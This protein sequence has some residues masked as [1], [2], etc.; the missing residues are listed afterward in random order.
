M[1]A[2]WLHGYSDESVVVSGADSDTTI[3]TYCTVSSERLTTID[4]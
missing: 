1:D 3:L 4:V 2:M